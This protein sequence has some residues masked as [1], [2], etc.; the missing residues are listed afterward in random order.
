M[1]SHAW[2]AG[3]TGLAAAV[4]RAIDNGTP[5]GFAYK[6]EWD[7]R[8]DDSYRHHI[9]AAAADNAAMHRAVVL[10]YLV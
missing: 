3:K 1:I 4:A 8:C 6:A 10:S 2:H 5:E 9:E 7:R